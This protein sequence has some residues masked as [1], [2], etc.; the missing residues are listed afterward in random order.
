MRPKL[1]RG[2][3]DDPFAIFCG[4]LAADPHAGLPIRM[5]TI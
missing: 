3:V 2:D 5:T 1:L 4:L